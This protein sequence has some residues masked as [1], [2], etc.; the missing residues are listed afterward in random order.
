MA[1]IKISKTQSAWG[2]F[3]PFRIVVE[4][5]AEYEEAEQYQL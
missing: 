1:D 3:E 2:S 4:K 5:L